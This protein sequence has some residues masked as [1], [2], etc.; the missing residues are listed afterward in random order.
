MQL[1]KIGEVQHLLKLTLPENERL[2]G[3]LGN[4]ELS[5]DY[6]EKPEEDVDWK[7][8]PVGTLV[9]T[10][11][12]LKDRWVPGLFKWFT[13]YYFFHYYTFRSY[14][15]GSVD[16]WRFCRIYKGPMEPRDL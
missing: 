9:E 12:Y 4:I 10:R 14:N 3:D 8:V 7:N 5:R 16:E 11:D 13:P 2:G 15:N 6:I 1:K